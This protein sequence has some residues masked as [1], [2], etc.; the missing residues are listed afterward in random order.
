MH[1]AEEVASDQYQAFTSDFWILP[2]VSEPFPSSDALCPTP[3]SNLKTP[4]L[5]FFSNFVLCIEV[6][7]W[8]VVTKTQK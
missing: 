2:V 7:L 8:N 4:K 1:L 3:T 6:I 5:Y